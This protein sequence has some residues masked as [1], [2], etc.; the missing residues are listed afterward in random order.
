MVEVTST[1]DTWDANGRYCHEITVVGTTGTS[2]GDDF[3][4]KNGSTGAA[5]IARFKATGANYSETRAIRAP[6]EGI[7][8]ATMDDTSAVIV[9]NMLGG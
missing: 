9:A 1:T 5:V 6:I 4:V 2:A 7:K 3:I 8:I